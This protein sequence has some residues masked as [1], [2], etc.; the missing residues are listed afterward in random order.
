MLSPR[1]GNG[2]SRK[3]DRF[4]ASSFSA[5]VPRIQAGRRPKSVQNKIQLSCSRLRRQTGCLERSPTTSRHP[6]K[7]LYSRVLRPT[8]VTTMTLATCLSCRQH[9]PTTSTPLGEGARRADEGCIFSDLKVFAD[10]HLSHRSG[11][12][13]LIA[14]RHF[15]PWGRSRS[16]YARPFPV[17]ERSCEFRSDDARA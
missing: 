17:S 1:V 14:C 10:R 16:V 15:S 2:A 4:D 6:A 13:T 12:L 9:A 3:A 7:S 8:V 5:T 11:G